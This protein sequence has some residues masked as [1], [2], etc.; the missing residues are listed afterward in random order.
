MDLCSKRAAKFRRRLNRLRIE[1]SLDRGSRVKAGTRPPTIVK[2]K[3]A[4][5]RRPRARSRSRRVARRVRRQGRR[6]S[7]APELKPTR[8]R[9]GT[10]AALSH[11]S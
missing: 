9:L 2:V 3:R 8:R 1:V 11:P 5:E 7:L 10:C 6:S 4:A